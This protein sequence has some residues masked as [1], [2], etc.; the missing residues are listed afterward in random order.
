MTKRDPFTYPKLWPRR[1]RNMKETLDRAEF[2]RP[3]LGVTQGGSS[4]KD[5]GARSAATRGVRKATKGNQN[6]RTKK[7]Q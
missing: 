6:G 5:S 7:E 4:R 3:R 2:I 1:N